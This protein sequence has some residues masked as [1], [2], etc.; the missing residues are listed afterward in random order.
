MLMA[1]KP[2]DADEKV[3]RA[4]AAEL[5]TN[6]L[7]HYVRLNL[8][9]EDGIVTISGRVNSPA[10]LNCVEYAAKRVAGIKD[11]ILEIRAAANPVTVMSGTS[12]SAS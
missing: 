3:F 8:H 5:R 1:Q 2:L 10:E 6:R 12:V 9:V 4:V 11:L 7:L